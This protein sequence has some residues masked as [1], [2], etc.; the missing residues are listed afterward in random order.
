[1]NCYIQQHYKVP[2]GD[3]DPKLKTKFVI[4]GR[5]FDGRPICLWCLQ[6]LLLV[7]DAYGYS[8]I[9]ELRGDCT[10]VAAFAPAKTLIENS[11]L[12]QV[13]E[14]YELDDIKYQL[15]RN[16]TEVEPTRTIQEPIEYQIN[17]IRKETNR[18]DTHEVYQGR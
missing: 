5:L 13:F 11:P 16:L 15:D 1:M 10:N 12:K 17:R 4:A 9:G 3:I 7:A 8:Q 6:R 2:H 18:G 14:D